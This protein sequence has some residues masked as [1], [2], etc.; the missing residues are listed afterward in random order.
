MYKSLLGGTI[1][2]CNICCTGGGAD[3]SERIVRK[4]AMESLQ[5]MISSCDTSLNTF[6]SEGN[7]ES[8]TAD[9]LIGNIY[10]KK[11]NELERIIE[12]VGKVAVKYSQWKEVESANKA[13][14]VRWVAS[15]LVWEYL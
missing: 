10:D 6:L 15:I 5:E 11:E 7:V 1:D 2:W 4:D 3:S 14:Q 8:K 9:V 12:A 13:M